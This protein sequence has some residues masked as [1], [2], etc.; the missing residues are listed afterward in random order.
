M[1]GLPAILQRAFSTLLQLTSCYYTI[2]ARCDGVHDV[3]Y[4][5][6]RMA[7]EAKQNP[8]TQVTACNNCF[9]V[10]LYD[11]DSSS[12]SSVVIFN[13]ITTD[14]SLFN[15]QSNKKQFRL[16]RTCF[17]HSAGN[18][19]TLGTIKVMYTG[20]H[21]FSCYPARRE[22]CNMRFSRHMIGSRPI[23]FHSLLSRYNNAYWLSMYLR[24]H[25][26]HQR[27]RIFGSVEYQFL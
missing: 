27:L 20:V 23:K 24:P 6:G 11:C 21:H 18:R 15:K 22:P 13:I 5:R 12:R 14:Y 2:V 17:V 1:T 10:P 9:V 3:L 8:W 16:T 7:P 25:N 19:P 26:L 4:T